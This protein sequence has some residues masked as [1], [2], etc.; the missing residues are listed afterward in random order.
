M[1]KILMLSIGAPSKYGEQNEVINRHLDY[2]TSFGGEIHILYYDPNTIHKEYQF[3]NRLF[4]YNCGAKSIFSY[5]IYTLF[6]IYGLIKKHRFDVVYTQDPF[7][8]ASVAR[9][10][11]FLY[12]IPI[13]VGSHASFLNNPNW[14]QEKPI[15]FSLFNFMAKINL[16]SADAL[17][18]VSVE[19]AQNYIRN[20][21]IASEKILV[22]NT[23]VKINKFATK[24][25]MNKCQTLRNN[26]G[27]SS[28]NILLIWVGRPVK[29]KRIP[30]LLKV[31]EKIVSKND[32]IKLLL[33]GK[34]EQVQEKEE[35]ALLI[36]KESISG[37]VIWLKDGIK[38]ESLP[39]YYQ[40]ADIYVHTASYEGLCKSIVEASASGLPVVT[41]EFSGLSQTIIPNG[42]G[43]IVQKDDSQSFV[44]KVLKLA[45]DKEL[46]ME[47][48]VNGRSFVLENFDY[49]KGVKNITQFWH[50]SI[51]KYNN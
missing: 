5:P 35:V 26:L 4:T 49:E 46:R 11:R 16:K 40:M 39:L 25:E 41:T 6:K 48:G 37:K 17:K 8:T 20:L 33:I 1:Y 13:I 12:N 32:N 21:K 18:S 31:F 3:E 51:I 47:M 9:V 10:A 28:S 30:Y 19:E 44:E 50:K 24:L 7:G 34:Y 43:F 14:I 2:A 23:P 29:Q 22:Q 36:E 45:D 42:S 15:L 27:I 38:N